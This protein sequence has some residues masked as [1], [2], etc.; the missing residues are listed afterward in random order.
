MQTVLSFITTDNSV[1]LAGDFIIFFDFGISVGVSLYV[2][3]FWTEIHRLAYREGAT[4]MQNVREW[5]VGDI[6]ASF[7][8]LQIFIRHLCVHLSVCVCV[9]RWLAVSSGSGHVTMAAYPLI[10]TGESLCGLDV[11]TKDLLLIPST[12]DLW[13]HRSR[14]ALLCVSA[15]TGLLVQVCAR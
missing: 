4:D 7:A 9:W 6:L 14:S 13:H 12:S 15:C 5:E 8:A 3:F 1:W 11:K 2:L 10:D